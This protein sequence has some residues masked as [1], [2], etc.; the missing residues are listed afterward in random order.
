[1]IIQIRPITDADQFRAAKALAAENGHGVLQPTHV[2]LKDGTVVGAFSVSL[3]ALS[4]WLHTGCSPRD[5]LAAFQGMDT[6]LAER[7][8]PMCLTPCERGSPYHDLMPR[9]EFGFDPC[10]GDWS[11]FIKRV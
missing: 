6:I 8:V 7:G 10:P 1:M 4:W 2:I 3:P 5:S 11:L 9:P